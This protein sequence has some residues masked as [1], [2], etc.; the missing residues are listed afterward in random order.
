MQFGLF[1]YFQD[2]GT[3]TT[4]VYDENLG[5]IE[6][7]EE[8]GYDEVWLAEHH[9]STYGMIPSPN[10]ILANLAAR[11]ARL[12]L[13]NMVSVLPFYDPLRLAEEVA[14]LDHLTHRRLNAGI[15]SGVRVD[16]FERY[17]MPMS[18]A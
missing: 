4:A 11:T 6:L 12:R 9:L 8:L 2:R 17:R 5:E 13:G 10:L 3:P 7:A 14:M 15:G 16:E 18:E 1:V